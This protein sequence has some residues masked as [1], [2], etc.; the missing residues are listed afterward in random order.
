MV[1][2][3]ARV[4]EGCEEEGLKD[5]CEEPRL[6][7]RSWRSVVEEGVAQALA[8]PLGPRSCGGR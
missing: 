6:E 2:A 4:A 7:R 3:E 8:E 5:P 1:R